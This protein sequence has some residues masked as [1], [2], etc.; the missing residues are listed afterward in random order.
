MGARAPLGMRWDG[1]PLL[2]AVGPIVSPARH[3][4][5]GAFPEHLLVT[6]CAS[7]FTR[8]VL[9]AHFIGADARPTEGAGT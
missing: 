3:G 2:A 4:V 5:S 7:L 9:L 6:C 1:V 8:G